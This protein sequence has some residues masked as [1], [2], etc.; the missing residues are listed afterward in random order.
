MQ[1][2]KVHKGV[3]IPEVVRQPPSDRATKYPIDT[4]AVGDMFCIP[5]R[6]IP[7][8]SAQMSNMTKDKPIRVECRRIHTKPVQKRDG[9]PPVWVLADAD[10]DGAVE[11]VGVWRTK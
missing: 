7:S 4:M 10:E 5:E 3:P 2:F 6:K 8:V 1:Q 9:E 11:G